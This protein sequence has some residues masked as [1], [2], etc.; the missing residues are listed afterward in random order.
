MRRPGDPR[1][2]LITGAVGAAAALALAAVG[3]ASELVVR[4]RGDDQLG[5]WATTVAIV[6]N[7]AAVTAGWTALILHARGRRHWRGLSV[8]ALVAGPAAVTVLLAPVTGPL[9][10]PSGATG[11]ALGEALS[12][13]L[14]LGVPALLLGP[15]VAA[16]IIPTGAEPSRAGWRWYVVGGFVWAIATLGG[17]WLLPAWLQI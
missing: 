9:P 2:V 17:G 3:V 8:A 1:V 12:L 10:S 4:A 5:I 6:L 11:G 13:S 14:W 7:L 15:V 16:M